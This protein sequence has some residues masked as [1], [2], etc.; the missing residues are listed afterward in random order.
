MNDPVSVLLENKESVIHAV[1][2]SASVLAAVHK[3]V[4]ARIGA[5]LVV[6]NDA[7]VGIFSE[8]DV[9][10][11]VV[12]CGRDPATTPVAHV[13]THDPETVDVTTTIDEVLDLHGGK[14]FR[15]LPVTDEGD[16]VGIVSFRDIYRWIAHHPTTQSA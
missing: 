1:S 3:M 2:P 4:E 10:V 16:L 14:D 9:L 15:H 5:V 12:N 7:L 11:R 8:R 13:M 6:E